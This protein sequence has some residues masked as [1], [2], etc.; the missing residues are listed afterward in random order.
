MCGFTLAHY[1]PLLCGPP[2]AP[3][4][5]VHVARFCKARIDNICMSNMCGIT[6]YT[7]QVMTHSD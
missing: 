6:I 2:S 1:F 3:E 4:Y 7:E 5:S